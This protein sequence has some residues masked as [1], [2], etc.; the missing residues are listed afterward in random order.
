M[1]IDSKTFFL[2]FLFSKFWINPLKLN[3]PQSQSLSLQISL[4]LTL[5]YLFIY[6]LVCVFS[7]PLCACP[8]HM[9][10]QATG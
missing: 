2:Y 7:A 1:Y 3:Q 10:S 8:E 5:P 9:L 6:L 4:A